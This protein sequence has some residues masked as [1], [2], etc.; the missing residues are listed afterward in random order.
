MLKD[1]QLAKYTEYQWQSQNTLDYL[2]YLHFWQLRQQEPFFLLAEVL[3][4]EENKETSIT[5][6]RKSYQVRHDYF[7]N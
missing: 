3:P 5:V 2:Y 1:S 7:L 4:N 6:R